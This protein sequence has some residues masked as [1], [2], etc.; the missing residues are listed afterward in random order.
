MYTKSST[1][2]QLDGRRV[3]DQV[4]HCPYLEVCVVLYSARVDTQVR[5]MIELAIVTHLGVMY[6]QVMQS[7]I[8]LLPQLLRF[9]QR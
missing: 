8:Y 5:C 4:R 9:P 2:H 1:S 7:I 6:Q 3:D